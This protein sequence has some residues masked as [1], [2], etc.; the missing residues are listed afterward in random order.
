M[1]TRRGF[2]KGLLGILGLMVFGAPVLRQAAATPPAADKIAS[3]QLSDAPV[4]YTGRI[5]VSM[6]WRG[7]WQYQIAMHPIQEPMQ[8]YVDGVLVPPSGAVYIGDAGRL[9]LPPGRLY[10]R[11]SGAELTRGR[12]VHPRA[13]L[14]FVPTVCLT[15]AEHA[16]L[17]DDAAPFNIAIQKGCEA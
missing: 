11:H 1:L 16:R 12:S 10:F 17:Q 15:D 2:F 9:Y 14:I 3:V 7:G 8:L 13:E 6:P 5:E 4:L